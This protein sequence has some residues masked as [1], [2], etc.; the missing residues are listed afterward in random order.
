MS[1]EVLLLKDVLFLRT[2]VAGSLVELKEHCRHSAS[3]SESLRRVLQIKRNT[4][5]TDPSCITSIFCAVIKYLL[6]TY[7]VLWEI[8]LVSEQILECSKGIKAK[9]NPPNPKP[10]KTNKQANKNSTEM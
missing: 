8:V 1:S 3:L 4:C 2:A 10:Q 5:D 7:Y 6:S 9:K